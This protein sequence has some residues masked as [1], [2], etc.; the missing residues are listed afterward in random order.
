MGSKSYLSKYRNCWKHDCKPEECPWKAR[1]L[2]V[3]IVKKSRDLWTWTYE[4]TRPHTSILTTAAIVV[5]RNFLSHGGYHHK[6][7]KHTKTFL[8]LNRKW[9]KGIAKISIPVESS[10]LLTHLVLCWKTLVTQV[11]FPTSQAA[12]AHQDFCKEKKIFLVRG[13]LPFRPAKSNTLKDSR[14]RMQ[15][16]HTS[17]EGKSDVTVW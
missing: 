8:C 12:A 2:Q 11:N 17:L 10:R 14:R 13:S 5:W 7:S 16:R 9:S 15:I 6:K 3:W 1:R 4:A